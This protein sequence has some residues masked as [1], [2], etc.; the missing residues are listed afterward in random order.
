MHFLEKMHLF[1]KITATMRQ[2]EYIL[3][4]NPFRCEEGAIVITLGS[5]KQ[6]ELTKFYK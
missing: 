1:I 2:I 3:V 4:S 5:E 6:T